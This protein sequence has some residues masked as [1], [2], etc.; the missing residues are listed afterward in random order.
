MLKIS[1]L[2]AVACLLVTAPIASAQGSHWFRGNT[3]THTLQSDGDSPPDSVARWYRDH[4]YNFLFITDHEKLTDPGPL[5]ARYGVPGKY[6]LIQGQE[7]TQRVVD[8]THKDK[9]R[10]A[11]MNSL[12]ASQLVLPQGKNGLA[13]GIIPGRIVPSTESSSTES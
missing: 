5:N 3:H 6:L 1:G 13:S 11:H 9:I 4:G 12:G 2:L 8:S 7:V 10:Q